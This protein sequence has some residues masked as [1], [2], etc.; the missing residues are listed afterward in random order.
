[1]N[2]KLESVSELKVVQIQDLRKRKEN[3][4]QKTFEEFLKMAIAKLERGGY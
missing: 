2:S 1:M 3:R 4:E